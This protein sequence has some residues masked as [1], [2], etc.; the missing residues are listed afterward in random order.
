MILCSCDIKKTEV[1]EVSIAE[2]DAVEFLFSRLDEAIKDMENGRV[3]AEE[4]MWV[5]IDAL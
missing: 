2:G 3:L 4:E 1:T 5:D